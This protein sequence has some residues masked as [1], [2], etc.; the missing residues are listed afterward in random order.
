VK[1]WGGAPGF[2]L[3]T[4]RQIALEIAVDEKIAQQREFVT[5]WDDNVGVNHGGDRSK[6]TDTVTLLDADR[7]HDLT[8]IGKMQVSRWRKK[9]K[10]PEKYR[11]AL[12][13][14]IYR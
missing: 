2:F 7:A 9:L 14:A 5:W 13:H 10:D 3:S 8:G 1:A 11:D 4:G 6:V 12:C